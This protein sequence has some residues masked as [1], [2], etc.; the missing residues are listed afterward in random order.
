[1][2]FSFKNSL[3]SNTIILHVFITYAF[4]VR[5]LRNI[6]IK[7]QGNMVTDIVG[8]KN[9]IERKRMKRKFLSPECNMCLKQLI[10]RRHRSNVTSSNSI[11]F[12]IIFYVLE[13]FVFRLKEKKYKNFVFFFFLCIIIFI[14]IF[15]IKK[16]G[17][18]AVNSNRHQ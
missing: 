9:G 3:H 7:K 14:T 2:T 6:V 17:I 11:I 18:L 5:K 1:M 10:L 8:K 15:F 4:N 16:Y 13:T 12:Y